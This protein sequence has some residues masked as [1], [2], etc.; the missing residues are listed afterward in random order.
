MD[1]SGA[2]RQIAAAER[3]TCP[4]T[5]RP[6]LAAARTPIEAWRGTDGGQSLERRLVD[7]LQLPEPV[8]LRRMSEILSGHSSWLESYLAA[9]FSHAAKNEAWQPP[10]TD[11]KTVSHIGLFLIERTDLKLS[12][13]LLNPASD[14]AD[15]AP[16][17]IRLSSGHVMLTSVTKNVQ[18]PVR[19]WQMSGTND[20]CRIKDGPDVTLNFAET[21]HCQLSRKYI[22]PSPQKPTLL[23]RV[24]WPEEEWSADRFF[25]ATTGA[26]LPNLMCGQQFRRHMALSALHSLRPDLAACHLATSI[27][28]TPDDALAWHYCRQLLTSAPNLALPMLK[29]LSE[30]GSSPLRQLASQTLAVLR[31][32]YP[33]L[34]AAA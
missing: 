8:K 31:S 1:I 11:F 17:M 5:M 6:A 32:H 12:L 20:V 7:A 13:N 28:L 14:A 34:C 21:L 10:L 29:Q 24:E 27:E 3:S 25:D 19:I 4:K 26:K 22:Q 9:L 30:S 18:M 2:L 23:L 16:N 15:H 33:S